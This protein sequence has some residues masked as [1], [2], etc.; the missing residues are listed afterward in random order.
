M[1]AVILIDGGYFRQ[2]LRS[3]ASKRSFHGSLQSGRPTLEAVAFLVADVQRRVEGALSREQGA[4]PSIRWLRSYYY[5]SEPF[6]GSIQHP[7]GHAVD[8]SKNRIVK[9]QDVLLDGLRRMQ[10][11]DL[12]VGKVRFRGWQEI[13]GKQQPIFQ[14][15]GVD[16]MIGL[17]VALIATRSIAD[18]VVL[19]TA[20]TDFIEPLKL[21]RSEGVTTCLFCLHDRDMHTELMEHADVHIVVCSE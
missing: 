11:M 19:V 15:K 2:A 8:F 17:D 1:K 14:Q 21:A 5:D 18:I 13:G 12:R 20:D 4:S 6:R 7:S 3:G 16:M 9:E 10:Q